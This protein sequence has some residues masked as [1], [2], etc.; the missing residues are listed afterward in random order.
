MHSRANHPQS[1]IRAVM[2]SLVA[3]SGCAGAAGHG[4]ARQA[5]QVPEPE[6]APASLTVEHRPALGEPLLAAGYTGVFVLLEPATRTLI[7]SDPQLAERGFIPAS[8]FK[9]PN[10]LIALETGV[11]DG[12]AF[13]LPWDGVDRW[14]ADWNRDHDLRSAFRVSAV[15]YYQELARRIGEQRM[16]EWVM[17]ADYGNENITGGVDMFWL[18]GGLRISPRE[19][20]EFLRRVHE[21]ASPFSPETVEVFL[22]EV[23]I[24]EQRDGLTLRAKTGWGR[25]Q[26]F[27]DPAAAGF[28]GHVGWYVGSVEKQDGS[29]IYFATL[30]LAPEPAPDSFYEDRRELGRS[31][32]REL[33]YW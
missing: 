11:A 22:D 7:V 29:R 26:D 28:D 20:V 10:S 21:G 19:Q 2:L 1:G 32:L 25:S 30:L 33:G 17:A 5:E 24:E 8:T 6:P 15:W 12:P 13:A 31:A 18:N 14:A 23:M 4:S 27:A 9:I 16:A 3:L